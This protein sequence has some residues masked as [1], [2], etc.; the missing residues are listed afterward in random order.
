[1]A[2]AFHAT[3]DFHTL[4]REKVVK[5]VRLKNVYLFV[6][7]GDAVTFAEEFKYE[8]AFMV[9]YNTSDVERTWKTKYGPK[10]VIKLKKG[11]TATCLNFFIFIDPDLE[12]AASNTVGGIQ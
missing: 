9:E 1:M 12:A 7:L 10:G 6:D 4:L 2:K 3:K 5:P 8:A 11:K